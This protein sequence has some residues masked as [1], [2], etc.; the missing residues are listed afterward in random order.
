MMQRSTNVRGVF[1]PAE[2][3]QLSSAYDAAL[4]AVNETDSA[5]WGLTAREVRRQLAAGIIDAARQGQLDADHL[6]AAA[7]QSLDKPFAEI[8]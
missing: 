1:G 7:L 5:E 6:K 4:S 2:I 8:D 3:A